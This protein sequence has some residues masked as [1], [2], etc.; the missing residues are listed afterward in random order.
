MA[1]LAPSRFKVTIL[2]RFEVWRED[3]PLGAAGWQRSVGTLLKLLA[4]SP[5]HRRLR[6]EVIDTLW[7]DATPEGGANNLRYV[8]S[9]LR[10]SLSGGEPTPILADRTWVTLNPACSWDIDLVRFEELAACAA[11]DSGAMEELAAIYRGEPFI[12][13]R[14][15][16]WAMPL[17]AHVQRT[18]LQACRLCAQSLRARHELEPALLWLERALEIDPLDE[19]SFRQAFQLLIQLGRRGEAMRRFQEFE[20]RLR[21]ELD[22][23]PSPETRALLSQAREWRQEPVVPPSAHPSPTYREPRATRPSQALPRG[24]YLGALPTVPLVARGQELGRVKA[25]V[26]AA[27]EGQGKLVLLG[28]EPGVGKTRLAQEVT[29]VLHQ[30]GFLVTTGRCYEPES[31]VPYYPFLDVLA[32]VSRVAPGQLREGVPRRWPYLVRLLPEL[33]LPGVAAAVASIE[34]GRTGSSLAGVLPDG[35]RDEPLL[36]RAVAGFL[37]AVAA[38]V[39][40]A[41]LLD[42]LHWADSASVK[43]LLH[44]ARHSGGQRVFLLGTYRDV[45]VAPDHPLHGALIDLGR[46]RLMEKIL[47]GRLDS[48]GT[49]ALITETL[50]GAALPSGL[51]E[52]VH[53]P[54]DGNPF[55]VGEIVRSMVEKGDLFQKNGAWERRQRSEIRVPESVR[56]VLGQRLSRLPEETRL[57]LGTAS[58]LGQTFRFDEVECV[59]GLPEAEVEA[60]LDEAIRAGLVRETGPDVYAFSHALAQGAVYAEMTGRRQRRLHLAAAETIEAGPELERRAVEIAFHFMQAGEV[61]RAIP[62]SI[63]AGDA[64]REVAAHA[65]AE[66]HYRSAVEASREIGDAAHEAA[67]LERLAGALLRQARYPDAQSCAEEAVR[68]FRH[69]GDQE[70]ELQATCRLADT[71]HAQRK[72]RDAFSALQALRDSLDISAVSPGLVR[73]SMRL[74]E[75]AMVLGKY[76]QQAELAVEAVQMSNALRDRRLLARAEWNRHSALALMGQ[77]N[78]VF[79]ALHEYVRI[80][81]H[82]GDLVQLLEQTAL[83]ALMAVFRGHLQS[84]R[85][86]RERALDLARRIGDP[87]AVP[88]ALSQLGSSLFL[89]GDWGGA[90]AHF[91]SALEMAGRIDTA[92]PLPM[93]VCDLGHLT[94][95][96]GDWD[97]GEALL[98]EASSLHEEGDPDHLPQLYLAYL[99]VRRGR[100]QAVIER[101]TPLLDRSGYE[102]FFATPLLPPLVHAHVDVGDIERAEVLVLDA[103]RRAESDANR[104]DLVAALLAQ[105]HLREKQGRD[106]GARDILRDVV[107]HAREMSF[108]AAEAEALFQLGALAIK[109]G[110]AGAAR[111]ALHEARAIWVLLGARKDLERVEEALAKLQS[112]TAD[113][114]IT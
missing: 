27:L 105:A 19:E 89:L 23:Q 50:D 59:S 34:P 28:G 25:E 112:S 18:W 5:E 49:E 73:L 77:P 104:L 69:L 15:E 99:D 11:G 71:L 65:E 51:V 93:T 53:G 29:T 41:V 10:R 57:V 64:A 22:V 107:R 62:H 60:A 92:T 61:A 97:A 76:E 43:L 108:P 85:E 13:D 113:S 42:D 68:A 20:R 6:D 67:A 66:R 83:L 36:I 103:L 24:A 79:A 58:V 48:E 106:D 1:E 78:D 63:L 109:C 95:C 33:Q 80:L 98:S 114:P 74:A 94:V 54:A 100:P 56:A 3:R 40:L 75:L 91:E 111:A 38:G 88:Y 96:E 110:D 90:R 35:D 16:D 9:V 17:R 12:E 101:L 47:L 39:P 52:I 46:E 55:F 82:D 70:G 31:A 32:D 87:M 21:S 86:Y 44:L 81:E 45:D 37:G 4:T 2:G 84:S 7:P 14:Y 8:L 72:Q 102:E 26:D 30:R